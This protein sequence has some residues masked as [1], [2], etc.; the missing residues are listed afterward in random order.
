MPTSTEN[1]T[2]AATASLRQEM[3]RNTGSPL[4]L[5][6]LGII[7][8]ATAVLLHGPIVRSLEKY[9]V[10]GAAPATSPAKVTDTVRSIAILPFEPLGQDDELLGLGMADAV[11]SKMS[12]LK[13]LVVLPTSAV[14]KYKGPANDQLAAGRALGV[15]A[16]LSGTI[17]RSGERIRAT[18]QLVRVA[19]GRTIWSD[20]FD[21]A[22]TDIFS[23]QDSISDKV[24]RSLIRD[25]SKGEQEQLSKHYT[26]DTAAYD[27]Y[28][29]GIYFWNKRSRDGLERAIDYFQRAVKQ[30]PGYALAYAVMAD[31]YFLQRYYGYDSAPDRIGNAKA[32]AERA[33]LLDDSIAESHLAA[34]AVQLCQNDYQAG[35][36]SFERAVALNPNLAIAHQRYALGTMLVRTLG[37]CRAR[38][39]T[40]PRTRPPFSH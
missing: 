13:Q 16:I 23:L 2:Q 10:G 35:M 27:S 18:I 1:R 39:E 11:I 22:F 8:L 29:M 28:L 31:C 12:N 24:A 30:D 4:A 7:L 36:Q 15:D 26:S 33:L 20:K 21:Q 17:Q 40:S 32:A 3:P 34:G 38:D 14:A 9:R 37:R 25:F 6:V 5:A 19:S